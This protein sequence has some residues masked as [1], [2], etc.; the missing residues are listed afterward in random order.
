VAQFDLKSGTAHA[1]EIVFDTQNVLIKG[2]GQINLGSE[3]LDLTVQGQ[4][5]KIRLVRVRAPVQIKGQ[6]LKPSFQLEVGHLL[7]QGAMGTD[8]GTLRTPFAAVLAFVDPGLAKDQDCAQLLA[9]TQQP[10]AS[11]TRTAQATTTETNR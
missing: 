5:K 3:R 8:Q 11:G 9:Q 4:P 6:L 2:G 1:Q 10:P 7:K